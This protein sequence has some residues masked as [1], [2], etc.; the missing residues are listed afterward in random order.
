MTPLPHPADV[1]L[2]HPADAALPFPADVARE[3]EGRHPGWVVLWRCWA[4]RYWAFPCWI[5]TGPEPVE[6]RHADDLLT[7]MRQVEAQHPPLRRIGQHAD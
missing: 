6:A 7:L 3:L 5:T 2:S 1:P 4:C